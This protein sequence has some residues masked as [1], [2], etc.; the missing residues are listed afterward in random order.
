MTVGEF[1]YYET[2]K[3]ATPIVCGHH[4]AGNPN[5]TGPDFHGNRTVPANEVF[6]GPPFSGDDCTAI[7]D[8]E[9]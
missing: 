3:A 1:I 7:S 2:D 9:T 6:C 5:I 8:C 4:F